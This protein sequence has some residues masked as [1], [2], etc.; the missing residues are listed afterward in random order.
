[1][2]IIAKSDIIGN[3]DVLI[4]II[5]MIK[6]S[7]SLRPNLNDVILCCTVHVA[8]LAV[9]LVTTYHYSTD[10]ETVKFY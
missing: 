5:V 2:L 8:L 1:M 3:R 9:K 6:F 4:A 7:L 10:D